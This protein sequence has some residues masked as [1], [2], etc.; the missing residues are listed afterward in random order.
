MRAINYFV[1]LKK[2]NSLISSNPR[3]TTYKTFVEEFSGT[4]SVRESERLWKRFIAIGTVLEPVDNKRWAWKVN[5][6]Y[7]TEQSVAKHFEQGMILSTRGRIPGKKYPPKAV[8][9]KKPDKTEL[10]LWPGWTSTISI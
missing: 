6:T 8:K 5:T 3:S 1:V 7:F 10:I 4:L 9:E 2:I